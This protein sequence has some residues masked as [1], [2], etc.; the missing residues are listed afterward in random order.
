[1]YKSLGRAGSP[2]M[3]PGPK[4]LVV[5][6]S[7]DGLMSLGVTLTHSPGGHAPASMQGSAG[8]R[9]ASDGDAPSIGPAPSD[10]PALSDGA[11]PSLAVIAWGPPPSVAD[12]ALLEEEP[13]PLRHTKPTSGAPS[14]DW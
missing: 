13:Q 11:A 1:M 4:A 7:T 3:A 14:T 2:T 10:D 8:G 12:P 5:G 6:A 9:A